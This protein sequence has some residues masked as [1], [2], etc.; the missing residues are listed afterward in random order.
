[1]RDRR[2]R[3]K[4]TNDTDK[5]YE[6]KCKLLPIS[7]LLRRQRQNLQRNEAEKLK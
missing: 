3:A 5:R 1:M 7:S 2:L 4:I 6:F